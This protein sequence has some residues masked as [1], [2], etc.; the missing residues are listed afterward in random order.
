L[1]L[2]KSIAYLDNN[3]YVREQVKTKQSL[4]NLSVIEYIAKMLLCIQRNRNEAVHSPEGKKSIETDAKM[5]Q[6]LELADRNFIAT[7]IHI[8]KI[9]RE[10]MIIMN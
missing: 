8:F 5:T 1:N 4:Y 3:Q 6:R 7:I 10:N 2:A 9:L